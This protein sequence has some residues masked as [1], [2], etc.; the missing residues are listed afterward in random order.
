[1]HVGACPPPCHPALATFYSHPVPGVFSAWRGSHS[2]F[3]PAHVSA[4]ASPHPAHHIAGSAFLKA[5]PTLQ[6]SLYSS[7]PWSVVCP[8]TRVGA[9][10][11][12]SGSL[13]YPR[14]PEHCWYIAGIQQLW[15]G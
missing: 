10:V 2:C 14:Y 11:S 9:Q 4:A 1:M 5:L 15:V 12:I 13:L 3:L 8:R 6:N 7:V